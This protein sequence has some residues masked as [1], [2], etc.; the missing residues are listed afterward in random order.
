MMQT[1]TDP[2]KRSKNTHF[3]TRTSGNGTKTTN[4]SKAFQKARQ[5]MDKQIINPI[6]KTVKKFQAV[7]L[8]KTPRT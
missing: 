6:V 4:K 3:I 2:T 7:K 8:H 5:K 1:Q